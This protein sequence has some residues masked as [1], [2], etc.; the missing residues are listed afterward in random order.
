MN[1]LLH[2]YHTMSRLWNPLILWFNTNR[3]FSQARIRN[4]FGAT[5][6]RLTTARQPPCY[7]ISCPARVTLPF[8]SLQRLLP[9]AVA[10]R[11]HRRWLW[12]LRAWPSRWRS[13]SHL[14]WWRLGLAKH[15]EMWWFGEVGLL[16]MLTRETCRQVCI[17]LP[18]LQCFPLILTDSWSLSDTHFCFSSPCHPFFSCFFYAAIVNVAFIWAVFKFQ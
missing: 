3:V 13:V 8:L 2:W 11:L 9:V 14:Q 5:G 7:L 1:K 10:E 18:R 16:R 4:G 17:C 12:M 6:S 15:K